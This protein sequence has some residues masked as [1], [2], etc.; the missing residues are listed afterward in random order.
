MVEAVTASSALAKEKHVF[1]T[2]KFLAE[3]LIADTMGFLGRYVYGQM[4]II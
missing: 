2:L 4:E 3:T 1:Q